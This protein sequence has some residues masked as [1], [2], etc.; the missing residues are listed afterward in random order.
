MSSKI[1]PTTIPPLTSAAS[2]LS[3][4]TPP[5]GGLLRLQQLPS[6]EHTITI[7]VDNAVLPLADSSMLDFFFAAATSPQSPAL[8]FLSQY[9]TLDEKLLQLGRLA[10]AVAF[11]LLEKSRTVAADIVGMG[12]GA[13]EGEIFADD[14]ARMDEA[15]AQYDKLSLT[16]T[17]QYK[18]DELLMFDNI[19]VATTKLEKMKHKRYKTGTA[20][21]EAKVTDA[22]NKVFIC[23]RAE[24][25]A[26]VNLIVS[27]IFGHAEKMVK[28]N[29]A[30]E[31]STTKHEIIERISGHSIVHHMQFRLPPPLSNREF[32]VASVVKRMSEEQTV[33]VWASCG[34]PMCPHSTE[35]VRGEFVRCVTLK[36][37][38]PTLTSLEDTCSIALGGFLP[39]AVNTQVTIPGII[40]S[41][42]NMMR[43]FSHVRPSSS[44]NIGDARE[45]G[46]LL[47]YSLCPLAKRENELRDALGKIMSRTTVLRASQS[48]YRIVD[49]LLF[50]VMRNRVGKTS[51]TVCSTLI[52]LNS[53]EAAKIGKSLANILLSSTT[54][55]HAVEEW[56][57][58]FPAVKEL[59]VEYTW[60]IPMMENITAKLLE[61]A[62]FGV[63]MRA[64]VGAAISIADML[65][66]AY[67]TVQYIEE[68]RCTY[69]KVMMTMVGVNFL[70]QMLIVYAVNY[71]LKKDRWKT[72][73]EGWL[74]VLL[75][76]KPGVDAYRVAT[77][78]DR[79]KNPGDVSNPLVEMIWGKS[80]EMFAEAIPGFVLQVKAFVESD[81]KKVGAALSLLTSACSASMSS[82]SSSFDYDLHP[83]DRKRYPRYA[84]II[85]DSG[86]TLA[87]SV[88][89]TIGTV[90]VVAKGVS[91][92]L[93]AVTNATW[94]MYYMV[95]DMAL[96]FVYKLVRRDFI[97]W[98]PFPYGLSVVVSVIFRIAT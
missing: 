59:S 50:H 69:A 61:Q 41:P 86:R 94:L 83:V 91:I 30:D 70:L 24:I 10:A 93:L 95:G 90:Q 32:V 57:A 13:G 54:A 11:R 3:S 28:L 34:H 71:K 62:S 68:G 45:L 49:E 75:C 76:I 44:Y 84:G 14:V 89:F 31:P 96:F 63:A 40:S 85:P 21:I 78:S 29:R 36:R 9:P 48:K 35:F 5:D 6:H 97:T 60:F 33:I 43:Y 65:S 79:G 7:S 17:M 2:S 38:T 51:F 87:F 16:S 82:T 46:L 55:E 27:Y 66:D 74:L 25:R 42:L 77:D 92:A 47:A 23:A 53:S 22:G 8:A 98:H 26:P 72:I 19:L 20:L 58:Q 18:P 88:L 80:A 1:F 81:N 12:G 64:G 56:C 73:L 4:I 37:I 15:A 39:N 67:V 52:T